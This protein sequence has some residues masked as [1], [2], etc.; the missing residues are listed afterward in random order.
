MYGST[1]F[2]GYRVGNIMLYLF[3][4]LIAIYLVAG[5]R[6][7]SKSGQSGWKIIIPIYGTY[8]LYKAADSEGLFYATIITNFLSSLAIR[9]FGSTPKLVEIR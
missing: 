5:A 2:L 3:L 1:Y 9:F 7:L 6:I 8:C 4:V